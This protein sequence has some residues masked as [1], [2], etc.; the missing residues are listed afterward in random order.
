MKLL[1]IALVAL[2]AALTASAQAPMPGMGPGGP[3]GGAVNTTAVQTYLG[4]SADQMATLESLRNNAQEETQ[5]VFVAMREKMQA[6]DANASVT[7]QKEIAAI[8]E[9]YKAQAVAVLTD[10]QRTKLA[11]L[12]EAAKLLPTITAASS[13]NL[14]STPNQGMGAGMGGPGR[15]GAS[16]MPMGPRQP[17]NRQNN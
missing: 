3:M 17:R 8:R 11:A 5:P 10:A 6:G 2:A 16:M 7:A 4:L 13:L 15:G 14:L 12:E 1:S 9:K